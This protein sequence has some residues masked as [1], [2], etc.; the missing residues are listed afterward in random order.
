MKNIK[1][2][3]VSYNPGCSDMLGE[4]HSVLV[5]CDK[6]GKWTMTCS[7][8]K[9]YSEPTTVT[10]YS[11][12]DESIAQFEE[13]IIKNNVFEL[14][15]RPNS[16]IFATDYTPWSWSFDYETT[17]FG[18]VKNEYCSFEEYLRYTG[19]DYE[20]LKELKNQLESMRGDK[21]SETTEN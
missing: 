17:S 6:G 14:S 8:R 10:T 9:V 1:L 20:L 15:K 2:N 3:R 5:R 21:I 11:V 18:Q 7:D 16:G 19:R 4:R 13:F 12:S